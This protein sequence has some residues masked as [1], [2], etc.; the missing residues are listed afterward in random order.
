M[1]EET[2]TGARPIQAVGTST[3]AI[4]GFTERGPKIATLVSSFADFTEKFGGTRAEPA[5]AL[6]DRWTRDLDDAGHWWQLPLSVKGFFDNGGEQAV[7]KRVFR[8]DPDNL[9]ADDF[10]AV[11]ESPNDTAD[12]SLFLAPGM[13]STK[14]QS[15]LISG[16]AAARDRFAILDPPPDLDIAGIREFRRRYQTDVAALYYPWLEVEGRRV[17]PSG[18]IA[19]IYARV[20][21]EYGVH[22]APVNQEI[23]S[24]TKIA[25]E[26]TDGEQEL[27]NPEGINALRFFPGRGNLVWGVRT[28]SPDSEW[29]YVNVR[30]FVT[31]LERSIDQGTQWTVFEPNG[32]GL[33]A[34]VRRTIED[35]LLNLW[36][37]GALQGNRPE[38]AFFVKCDRST[39]TQN[40]IDNGRL[41]CL[42]GVAVTRPAEFVIF[43]IGQWT[44]EHQS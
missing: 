44:A 27:L 4:F 37:T 18:H 15:A 8:D 19:G 7:I 17:A 5:P 43:R 40:D 3:A 34:N 14:I 30:R 42:V 38:D 11:I 36:Q 12:A 9:T 39:M 20:D 22:K 29:K 28:L 33:W 25:R 23:R 35:F 21:R 31:Y 2:S 24:I 41:I 32:E 16:C 13:W 10:V 6:R 1:A 26:V